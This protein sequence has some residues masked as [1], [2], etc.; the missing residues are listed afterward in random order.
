[1]LRKLAITTAALALFAGSMASTTA[2]A[3]AAAHAAAP[4][5]AT[6]LPHKP[7]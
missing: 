5:A 1:M 4:A 7:I 6:P 2:A 3:T